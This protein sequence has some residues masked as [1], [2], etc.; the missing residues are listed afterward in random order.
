MPHP[1]GVSRIGH[2]LQP[3]PQARGVTTQQ[4]AVTGRKVLKLLQGRTDQGE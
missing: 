4:R 1:A 2:P 3:F